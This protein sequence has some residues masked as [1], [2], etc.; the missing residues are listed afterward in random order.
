MFSIFAAF[1]TCT[2]ALVPRRRFNTASDALGQALGTGARVRQESQVVRTPS[3]LRVFWL[4]AAL[5]RQRQVL[6]LR[7]SSLEATREFYVAHI[8]LVRAC[9]S[10]V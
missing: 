8:C 4:T 1:L 5:P 10:G 9:L 3:Q 7:T 2:C 6:P